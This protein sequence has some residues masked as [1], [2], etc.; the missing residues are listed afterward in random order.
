MAWRTRSPAALQ[1]IITQWFS[2]TRPPRSRPP[3][4]ASL[5]YGVWISNTKSRRGRLD[6]DQLA[7][8]AALGMDWQGR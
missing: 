3:Q 6:A 7:A 2:M 5:G 4:T 1:G 8:L